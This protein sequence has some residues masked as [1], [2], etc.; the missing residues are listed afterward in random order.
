M[1]EQHRL[2]LVIL[3]YLLIP[4]ITVFVIT[5]GEFSND[6]ARIARNLINTSMIDKGHQELVASNAKISA[7]ANLPI[8]DAR[9]VY[10]IVNLLAEERMQ[11][12]ATVYSAATENLPPREYDNKDTWNINIASVTTKINADNLVENAREKGID[13]TQKYVVVNGK[14]YWRVSVKGFLSPDY[15]RTH[16]ILVKGLLGLKD[17]WISKEAEQS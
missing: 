16:S 17:V 9:K 13:A 10:D 8:Y 6:F 12:Q 5:M 14:K 1:N 4:T 2:Y 7:E 11:D 3:S 15:A